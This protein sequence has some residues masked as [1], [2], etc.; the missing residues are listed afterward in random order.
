MKIFILFFLVSVCFAEEAAKSPAKPS[1]DP[2]WKPQNYSIDWK[3]HA[4]EYFIFDCERGHYACV[5]KEGN[6]NCREE[7]N[8]A[9]EKKAEIYPC[10]PLKRFASKKECVL[11]NY[12][13]V[14]INAKRRFCFPK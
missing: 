13:I 5:D 9:L 3:Y 11:E 6:E 10:A 7:R 4:G 1:A 14:D 8:F 2:D 12:K